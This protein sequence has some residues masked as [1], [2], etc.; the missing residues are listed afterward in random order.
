[1]NVNTPFPVEGTIEAT[2]YGFSADIPCDSMWLRETEN[3]DILQRAVDRV[4]RK[5]RGGYEVEVRFTE[6][7]LGDIDFEIIDS[8]EDQKV[9]V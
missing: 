4:A 1:M 3:V 2:E 5:Y 7:S 8:E 9:K 6:E